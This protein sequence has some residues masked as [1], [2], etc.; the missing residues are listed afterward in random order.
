[1]TLNINL[2]D[3]AVRRLMQADGEGAPGAKRLE[4]LHGDKTPPHWSGTKGVADPTGR[5]AGLGAMST[6]QLD[7]NKIEVLVAYRGRHGQF[8]LTVDVYQLPGEPIEIVLICP[9]CQGGGRGAGSRITTE[10]KRIE[11]DRDHGR[12]YTFVDGSRIAYNGGALSVEPFECSFE[13]NSTERHVVGQRA[14]GANLCRMR[15]A[16]ENSIAKDA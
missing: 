16:I 11:F 7:K 2:T 5:A 14:G 4:Q 13:L 10:R 15:L 8:D 1:M 12:P 3:P 9:K 6:H